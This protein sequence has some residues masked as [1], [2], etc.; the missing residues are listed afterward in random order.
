MCLIALNRYSEAIGMF[1][2]YLKTDKNYLDIYYEIAICYYEIH[3]YNETIKDLSFIINNFDNK[4]KEKTI[5]SQHS[6]L[7]KRKRDIFNKKDDD[8]DNA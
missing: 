1:T 4:E 8:I 2:N 5:I 7:D 6:I 3:K